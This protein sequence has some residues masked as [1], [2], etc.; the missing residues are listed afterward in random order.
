MGGEI[1]AH[2]YVT[3]ENH[4]FIQDV[5]VDGQGDVPQREIEMG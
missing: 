2:G 3:M 1:R 4:E 5:Y